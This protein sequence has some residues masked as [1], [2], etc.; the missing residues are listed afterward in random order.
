LFT[1][2]ET[3]R[4]VYG[5]ISYGDRLPSVHTGED[6]VEYVASAGDRDTGVAI[7]SV[8]GEVGGVVA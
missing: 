5:K 6:K 2:R 1:I 4:S 8:L 7:A 3:E